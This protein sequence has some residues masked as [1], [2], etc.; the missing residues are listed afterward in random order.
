MGGVGTTFIKSFS[1]LLHSRKKCQSI[2]WIND[3]MI[4]ETAII[5]SPKK[6]GND[7][8]REMGAME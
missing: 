3:T 5:V 1:K 4:T 7:L 8:G 6:K 2:K